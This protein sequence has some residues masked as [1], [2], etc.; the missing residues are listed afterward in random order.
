MKFIQKIFLKW[1]GPSFIGRIATTII[2]ALLAVLTK[3]GFVIP[4]ETLA[5]FSESSQ[6]ILSIIFASVVSGAI[7][8][9]LSK[10]DLPDKPV[11]IEDENVK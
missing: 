11:L 10:R 6:V 4:P 1:F 2:S 3:Y 7:D 8:Q 9:T 5:Q